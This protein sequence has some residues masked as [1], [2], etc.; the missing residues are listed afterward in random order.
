MHML[1]NDHTNPHTHTHTHFVKCPSQDSLTYIDAVSSG[2]MEVKTEV[3]RENQ[4][5]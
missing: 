4:A 1:L 3:P 2:M 5:N